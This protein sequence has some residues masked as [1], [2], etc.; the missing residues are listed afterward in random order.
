MSHDSARKD[1]YDQVYGKKPPAQQ[2]LEPKTFGLLAFLKLFWWCTECGKW[3]GNGP[4]DC[5]SCEE[6]RLLLRQG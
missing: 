1:F 6:G 5:S 4:P 3:R 2:P